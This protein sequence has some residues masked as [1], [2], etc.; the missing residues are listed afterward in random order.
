MTIIG[1]DIGGANLKGA[2]PDGM[3]VSRPFDLWETPARLADELADLLGELPLGSAFAVAMTGELAD[4]YE[5]KAEQESQQ[6]FDD[7]T[8]KPDHP[9]EKAEGHVTKPVDDIPKAP[10]KKYNANPSLIGCQ[11]VDQ[12]LSV[13]F[14][15]YYKTGCSKDA[16]GNE[17]SHCE[18]CEHL[19]SLLVWTEATNLP[20]F[21]G[22][23]Q[24]A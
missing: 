8:D 1:L 18:K 12:V 24:A 17:K 10:E 5:T 7:S 14:F 20:D 9:T 3:A 16:A 15:R 21:A 23:N 6:D 2:T 4:C 22:V 11:L 13:R 19:L